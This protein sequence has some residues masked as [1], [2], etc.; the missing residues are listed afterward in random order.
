MDVPNACATLA[1]PL[2]IFDQDI[3]P[4]K[5]GP[6]VGPRLVTH[7]DVCKCPYGGSLPVFKLPAA[8]SGEI[9]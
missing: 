7:G 5:G 4:K 6:P 9:K 3:R 2:A 1:V 8:A